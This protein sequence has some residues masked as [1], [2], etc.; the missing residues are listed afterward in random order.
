MKENNQLNHIILRALKDKKFY[1][2]LKKNPKKVL[3]REFKTQLPGNLEIQVLEETENKK[4]LILPTQIEGEVS[5]K[6]LENIAG[7]TPPVSTFLLSA[8]AK[9]C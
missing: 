7:G 2:E 8:L 6:E 9:K 3:E 5:E 4:Y 1:E